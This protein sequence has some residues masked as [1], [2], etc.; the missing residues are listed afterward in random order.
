MLQARVIDLSIVEVHI[1][2]VAQ[3][4]EMRETGARHMRVRKVQGS[5]CAEARQLFKCAI[6]DACVFEL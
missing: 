3:P 4:A 1:F 6:R 2:Q 5:E